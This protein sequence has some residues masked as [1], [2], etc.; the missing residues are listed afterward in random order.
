MKNIKKIFMICAFVLCIE[1]MHRQASL[2]FIVND[3]RYPLKVGIKD[4]FGDE[5]ISEQILAPGYN[6][7]FYLSRFPW[8]ITIAPL[9]AGKV[10]TA[11]IEQSHIKPGQA[12]QIKSD[13]LQVFDIRSQSQE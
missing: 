3:A 6:L 5:I 9:K 2:S 4:A 10:F 13:G 12:L 1:P 8:I 7:Q 11:T